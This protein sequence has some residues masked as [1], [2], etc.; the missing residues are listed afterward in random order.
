MAVTLKPKKEAFVIYIA[1]LCTKITVHSILK[2]QIALLIVKKIIIPEE[3]LN[4]ANFFSK[5]LFV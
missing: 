3:Y 1:F 5:E 4:F 2:A